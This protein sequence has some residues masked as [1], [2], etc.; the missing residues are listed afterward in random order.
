MAVTVTAGSALEVGQPTALFGTRL[1]NVFNPSYTR[2]QYVVSSDG[3]RFLINQPVADARPSPITVV[4]NWPVT[5]KPDGSPS[6]I[7]R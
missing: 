3:T 4:V 6:D 7:Q 5:L 1:S 2:N